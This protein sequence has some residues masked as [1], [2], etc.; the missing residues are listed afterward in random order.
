MAWEQNAYSTVFVFLHTNTP[1]HCVLIILHFSRCV[2]FLS[3]PV[4]NHCR[5]K[6]RWE[7]IVHCNALHFKETLQT[8]SDTYIHTN[9]HYAPYIMA[10]QYQGHVDEIITNRD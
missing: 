7:S 3:L 1:S 4:H 2:P 10:T 5:R 6:S 9:L 8:P